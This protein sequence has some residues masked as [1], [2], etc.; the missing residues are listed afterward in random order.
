MNFVQKYNF[1]KIYSHKSKTIVSFCNKLFLKT[2]QIRW[3]NSSWLYLSFTIIYLNFIRFI[4][5]L[6]KIMRS[7]WMNQI[8]TFKNANVIN[9]YVI[10]FCTVYFIYILPVLLTLSQDFLYIEIQRNAIHSSQNVYIDMRL[11]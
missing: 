8:K 6:G 10:I 7:R 9:M 3:K 2:S 1:N 5:S 4:I 11:W